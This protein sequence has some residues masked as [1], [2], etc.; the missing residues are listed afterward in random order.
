MD[1]QNIQ[2]GGDILLSVIH[3]A[4]T[5]KSSDIHFGTNTGFALRV[6]GEV[7]R[8][9]ADN[10]DSGDLDEKALAYF[11]SQPNSTLMV[12]NALLA[13]MTNDKS[14]PYFPANMSVVRVLMDCRGRL[15]ENSFLQEDIEETMRLEELGSWRISLF[16]C[17]GNGVGLAMRHLPQEPPTLNKLMS[18]NFESELMAIKEVIK[19]GRGLILVTG[20]TGSGKTTTL[21]AIVDYLNKEKSQIIVT[22]EDPIEYRH[23]PIKSQIHHRQVGRD[24]P[25]YQLGLKG[26]L[27]QD[28]DTILLGELRDLETMQLALTAA[29]TG[30]LVMATL[31]SEDVESTITRFIDV[32]PPSQQTMVRTLLASSLQC[33]ISQRL[34]PTENTAI[35]NGRVL[36]PEIAILPKKKGS[37]R[38]TIQDGRYHQITQTLGTMSKEAGGFY[39]SSESVITRLEQASLI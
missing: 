33:V 22:L 37:V 2:T 27:R 31:H 12:L 28:P 32:F 24:V 26:A 16:R 7:M 30:H 35:P 10:V 9:D 36:V 34:V 3:L 17:D 13:V 38:A 1:C 11:R 18:Q 4:V 14:E 5:L 39:T 19:R 15:E 29:E 6:R 25:T 20:A 8:L 23:T 21:A